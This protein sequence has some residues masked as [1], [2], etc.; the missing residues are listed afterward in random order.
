MIKDSVTIACRLVTALPLLGVATVA[1]G[2]V[3]IAEFELV[4]GISAAGDGQK[5]VLPQS[6]PSASNRSGA[7]DSVGGGTANGAA[8]GGGGGGSA[9]GSGPSA[10]GGES[11]SGVGLVT[12]PLALVSY[13][14]FSSDA[15]SSSG[16]NDG[17]AGNAPLPEPMYLESQTTSS[18]PITYAANEAE[19]Q[20]QATTTPEP[21][22]LAIWAALA[23]LTACGAR[24]R[25]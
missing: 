2:G 17:D 8:G 19:L 12:D 3:M 25:S 22:A 1:Q 6:S 13:P 10:G 18:A 21:G 16:D 4:D 24:F 23:G 11:L 14:D 7:G 20:A 5:P 15:G 9:M